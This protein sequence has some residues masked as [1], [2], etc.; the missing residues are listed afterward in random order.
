MSLHAHTIGMQC[1]DLC[2]NRFVANT[3]NDNDREND[4][5]ITL[6]DLELP[7]VMSVSHDRVTRVVVGAV[8]GAGGLMQ[9]LTNS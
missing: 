8:G 4:I 5:L 6:T 3:L 9:E 1:Q 2:Q 7:V